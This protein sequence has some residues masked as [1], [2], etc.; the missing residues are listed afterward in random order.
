[1]TTKKTTSARKGPRALLQDARAAAA[2]PFA[3]HGF[4]N[5]Q[6]ILRWRDFAGP[7]LGQMSAPLS[8]SPEGLLTIS[9]D[10][11]VA[12]FLQHQTGPIVQR[13]NLALG[14]G[15]VRKVKVIKGRFSK[16]ATLPPPRALNAREL[17]WVRRQAEAAHD[18]DLRQALTRLG[19]SI[20]RAQKPAA[21]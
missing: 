19:E 7:V 3:A 12:L 15:M 14:A 1:M 13:V 21:K 8:L 4:D 5:P 11:S 18:P 6:L 17:Q 10:P 9:A 20:A 16:A 2:G